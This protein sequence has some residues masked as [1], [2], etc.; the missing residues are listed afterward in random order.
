MIVVSDTTPLISLMKAEALAILEPLFNEV[1]IPDAVFSELTTNPDFSDEAETIRSCSFIK[2]VTVKEQQSVELLQ[3]A[4]GLDLGES[5]AIIYADSIKADVLLMDETRGRQVART[6][7]I[8][9]MGTIGVL[10]FAYEEKVLSASDVVEILN[11]LK[12][13]NR[14]I[15]E[16]L[17]Q[18]AISKINK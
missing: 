8:Y 17:I 16:D 9:Y 18:Y 1:L 10:L 12:N 4:T 14:H 13:A 6:M 5:E 3:R 7:G 11:R 15:S 2:I